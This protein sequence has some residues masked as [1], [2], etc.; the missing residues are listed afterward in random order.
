MEDVDDLARR[1]QK[2][3]QEMQNEM[4]NVGRQI[5]N[6]EVDGESG[7][8]LV[9]MTLTA[10]GELR[11]LSIDKSVINP[12]DSALLEDLIKAAYSDT[13][14]KAEDARLKTIGASLR[15]LN[16]ISLSNS[17]LPFT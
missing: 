14:R 10:N 3:K 7:A 17:D 15:N 6:L 4:R 9:R 2:M 12:E 8:G 16:Q 1:T 5:T 13:W 11:A